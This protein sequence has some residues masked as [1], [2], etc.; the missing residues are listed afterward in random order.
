MITETTAELIDNSD[1]EEGECTDDSDDDESIEEFTIEVAEKELEEEMKDKGDD[2]DPYGRVYRS[3]SPK[4]K[5]IK[6]EEKIF[7]KDKKGVNYFSDGEHDSDSDGSKNE[8]KKDEWCWRRKKKPGEVVDDNEF[9]GLLKGVGGSIW[10]AEQS[11]KN[12][13]KDDTRSPHKDRNRDDSRNFRG[14]N[15]RAPRTPRYN[16]RPFPTP[17]KKI[18]FKPFPQP[19]PKQPPPPAPVEKPKEPWSG[20]R[21]YDLH[22]LQIT[23]APPPPLPLPSPSESWTKVYSK[24]TQKLDRAIKEKY[25]DKKRN[26]RS[27]SEVKEAR[28]GK[29]EEFETYP[30]VN[31][32]PRKRSTSRPRRRRS[33]TPPRRY[34]PRRRQS[35]S[36]S[37]EK[38]IRSQIHL[39]SPEYQ[40]RRPLRSRDSRNSSRGKISRSSSPR[41]EVREVIKM[42]ENDLRDTPNRKRKRMVADSLPN[43]KLH[44]NKD[45][46]MSAKA[47]HNARTYESYGDER[48]Y[49]CYPDE[50]GN[51]TKRYDH[52]R[53]NSKSPPATRNSRYHENH[54]R[55]ASMGGRK[56]RSSKKRRRTNLRSPMNSEEADE[57]RASIKRRRKESVSSSRSQEKKKSSSPEKLS[58]EK[59]SDVPK[60]KDKEDD[61]KS[62]TTLSEKQ[63]D[64]KENSDQSDSDEDSSDDSSSDSESS[65][66]SKDGEEN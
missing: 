32:A 39:R 13:W 61:V 22:S 6:T 17:P 54:D 47:R 62:S 28:K 24:D 57:E 48:V 58:E 59:V 49:I 25:P 34:R 30:P 5:P 53:G 46:P 33:Q 52:Y 23:A 19:P 11:S 45:A 27:E 42:Q 29:R 31:P 65:S 7:A 35:R 38:H 18:P 44:T 10:S 15:N 4:A 56:G 63:D 20:P 66:S 3:E 14:R 21:R 50:L 37:R 9:D 43:K 36:R 51:P 41:K 12:S 55:R 8:R 64:K 40:E 16:A 1:L 2:L 26:K 60:K